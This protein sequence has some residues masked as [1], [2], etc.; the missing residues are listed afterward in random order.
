METDLI[1]LMQES[2]PEAQGSS[3][4]PLH[5][6]EA[7]HRLRD[8]GHAQIRPD[9]VETILRGLAR[10]GR[11]QDG[12]RGNMTLRKIS[13]TTISVQLGRSWSL[14]TRTA[15]LR[16]QGARALLA[17]LSGKVAKG[18]RGRDLQVD[19][20]LGAM[21]D[22][23]NGDGLLRAEVKDMTRLMDRAMMWLH[24]QHIVTL[25][26]GLTI[27]RPALTLHLNPGGGSFTTQN[28]APLEEHYTEQTIQTHVMAAYAEAGLQSIDRA[29][30]LAEDYFVLDR[31]AFLRRYL[32]GRAA[33]IRRQTTP[34][35]WKLIV[36]AL[37]N[38]AQADIVRDD[39][40]ATRSI[41]RPRSAPADQRWHEAGDEVRV[42]GEQRFQNA[43]S[44]YI[45]RRQRQRI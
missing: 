6:T 37:D 10:D 22:A 35:S 34:A 7:C 32:P 14:V 41:S 19:T 43:Y 3:P 44:L 40:E 23:L 31:D 4:Q 16:R 8:I 30:R 29:Q 21:L 1:A 25:G 42:G 5:L 2:V 20:T 26:P 13:R 28:F 38:P 17:H 39:R 12:G 36:E 24:E 9:I 45:E 18:A 33:E 15:D 27:F 11:D